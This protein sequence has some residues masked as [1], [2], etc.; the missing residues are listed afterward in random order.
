VVARDRSIAGLLGASP[1]ASTAAPIMLNV[2]EKAFGDKVATPALQARIRE[3]VPSY[4]TALNASPAKVQEE[5]NST[6]QVL[7]LTPPPVIP[8][9][10]Q[11]VAPAGAPAVRQGP[12]GSRKL[13]GA[14]DMAL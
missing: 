13:N 2:L 1:G 3:I 12:N 7:Q 14:T 10:A 11:G 6:A 5:W 9:A 8:P 4:G